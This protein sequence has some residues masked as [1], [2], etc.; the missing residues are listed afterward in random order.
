M[1]LL[2][3]LVVK[4]SQQAQEFR[5][6]LYYTK[7]ILWICKLY[8][9]RT[10]WL[11]NTWFIKLGVPSIFTC[12]LHHNIITLV[13]RFLSQKSLPYPGFVLGRLSVCQHERVYC[14]DSGG[15]ASSSIPLY[16]S[17]DD[18]ALIKWTSALPCTISVT[19]P[20]ANKTDTSPMPRLPSEQSRKQT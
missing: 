4:C 6:F 17:R 14:R 9:Y 7:F 12:Y 20:P 5:H 19:V 13:F 3:E 15:W 8:H 1:V 16:L 18:K 11:T 2:C 10:M